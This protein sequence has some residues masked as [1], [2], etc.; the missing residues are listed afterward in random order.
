METSTTITEISKALVKAQEELTNVVTNS[1]NP[2]FKSK[3]ADLASVRDSATPVLNKNGLAVIQPAEGGH[4]SVSVTT[5]LIHTSGEWMESTL[6]IKPDKPNAQG[7]GS[8]I[9]YARRYMFMSLVGI[10]PEDDDGNE[11]TKTSSEPKYERPKPV[12]TPS[13]H[14][15][16]EMWYKAIRGML[17]SKQVSREDIASLNLGEATAAYEKD[18]HETLRLMHSG[19]ADIVEARKAV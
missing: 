6:T 5:R 12:P 8:A 18:D 19:L 9:T 11:A 7:V 14:P 3:Y 1:T 17:T 2:H 4:E 15:D 10:A 16:S 13:K